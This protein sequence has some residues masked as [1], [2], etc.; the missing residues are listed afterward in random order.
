LRLAAVALGVQ[1]VAE[2]IRQRHAAPVVA[3]LAS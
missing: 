1:R 2:A 3:P